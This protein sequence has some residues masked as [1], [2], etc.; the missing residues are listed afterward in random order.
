MR[1]ENA[2]L[3]LGSLFDGIGGFPLAGTQAGIRPVWASEIEPF[4]IRVVEKRLPH[5]RHYGDVH[6]LNGGALEPVDIITFGSPCQDLSIAGKR[7]GLDGA[8]SGLFH[9]AV[10]VIHEM[11]EKTNGRYPRWAVWENVPGALSSLHGRD[12]REVLEKLIHIKDSEADVPMPPKDQ[13]LPA[14]EILGDSYSLAWRV[15]DAAQGWGVAQRRKRV[16]VVLDLDGQ[17]AGK[18]LFES[19]GMSG[20]SPPR[21]ET[22]QRTAGSASQSTA[23]TGAGVSEASGFCTEHSANS[24]GIGFETERSPTLRAGVVPGIAIKAYGI[25]ADQSNAMLSDNP[26]AG[27]YEADTSRTLD[28]N[29]GNPSC[30]QGGMAVVEPV[31]FAQNQRDEVRELGG[32]SGT[33]S[34]SPGI[35]QQTFIAQP[36]Q[37]AYCMTTGSFTQLDRE[38]TPPIMARDYKDPPVIGRDNPAY[39]LDRACFTSGENAQYRMN[40]SPE[41]AP[42]LVAEGPSAVAAPEA[43]YLVRRLTPGEC[44]RLQGYPDGWCENLQSENPSDAECDKWQAIFETFRLATGG[45]TKPKTRKQIIKWLKDPQSDSAEYKAYGNSV[46]VPCVFFVLAGIVW[47]AERSDST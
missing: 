8:R 35:H 43:D 19:E 39:A 12:F 4:P 5:V 41:K 26:H 22:R 14:G 6:H 47:A 10:R 29:G 38:K 40:V 31:A 15:L 16:F 23:T 27:I 37:P 21:T 7:S 9:E 42:T 3:T 46:A 32:Q 30:N 2:Q 28:C 1:I 44:C 45:K 34:A 36:H 11:R 13:W 18:V 33:I 25:S 20:Y 24:R 17:C